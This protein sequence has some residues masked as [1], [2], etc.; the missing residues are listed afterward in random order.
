MKKLLPIIGCA[1]VLML[2]GC[3]GSVSGR[4]DG[5]WV[6]QNKNTPMVVTITSAG[7]RYDVH[8][9]HYNDYRTIGGITKDYKAKE[10]D[11]YTAQGVGDSDLRLSKDGSKL[12][13]GGMQAP[14][15]K[16]Q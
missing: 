14:L 1:L 11:E 2:A 10:I 15:L 3:S 6:Q 8:V 12:Y 5:T 9:E 16:K 4:F 7:D 13:F